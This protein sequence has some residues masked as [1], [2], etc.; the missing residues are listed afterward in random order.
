MTRRSSFARS[1]LTG[2][3][4]AITS[5]ACTVSDAADFNAQAALDEWVVMWNSYD[6]DHVDELFLT[7]ANVSYLS[8]ER[9]GAIIGIDAVREHHM[10]FGF[11]SGGE[12]PETT[13]W[14]EDVEVTTPSGI[15]VV[16]GTWYFRRGA[17]TTAEV[18]RGPVT[19]VYVPT[20]D[21]FRIAHA[22]F[23]DY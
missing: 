23:A 2:S 16:T 17:D 18:Q 21:G 7:D 8:S 1:V 9:E 3:L 15:V 4:L 6:L 5:T 14:M 20:D 10:G 19:F 11:V 13:L 22:H 12:P